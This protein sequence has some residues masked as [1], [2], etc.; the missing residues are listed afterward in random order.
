MQPKLSRLI[1][2]SH[3]DITRQRTEIQKDGLHTGS[4]PSDCSLGAPS[5]RASEAGGPR[6]SLP[7]TYDPAPQ[8]LADTWSL[9]PPH[10]R[11]AIFTLVDS[12]LLQQKL[13]GGQS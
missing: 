7:D 8:Y 4:G 1:L 11:E 2:R 12:A 13:T 5:E 10:V 3:P 9:L 6:Q